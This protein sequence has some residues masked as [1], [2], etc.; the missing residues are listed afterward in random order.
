MKTSTKVSIVIYPVLFVFVIFGAVDVISEVV[1]E[2]F[3]STRFVV[4]TL[5][6]C[7]SWI[8]GLFLALF[9]FVDGF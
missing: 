6:V 4:G 8:I 5:K 9:L 3:S 7:F 1:L 2:N